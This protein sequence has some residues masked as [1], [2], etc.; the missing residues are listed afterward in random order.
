[1]H[2]SRNGAGHHDGQVR[3]ANAVFT[4]QPNFGDGSYKEGVLEETTDCV[5]FEFRSP[6]VIAATP[7]NSDAWG[8]YDQG[9]R[10]GLVLEGRGVQASVSTDGGASW[11][12]KT[13][14]AGRLDLTDI[15]KGGKQYWL[16][17]GFNSRDELATAGLRWTTVCQTNV[18]VLPRLK[19]EGSEITYQAS[20]QALVSAGPTIAQAKRHLVAGGFGQ[21]QVTLELATPRGEPVA[22]VFAATQVASSNPPDPR[23]NYQIEVA[24][25]GSGAWQPLVRDWN[26][27]RRGQEPGDFWSQSFCWGSQRLKQETGKVKVRFTNNGGKTNLRSEM[28]LAYRVGP[29]D[30]L[31]VTYAWSDSKSKEQRASNVFGPSDAAQTWRIPTAKSVVTRWVEMEP[32]QPDR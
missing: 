1:M 17:I 32:A 6:Y 11:S 25:D 4:Y 16:R 12:P 15:V 9:C 18:A 27:P 21:K 3:F 14:L 30:P 19:E 7:P 8:I 2:G 5:T 10:N 22:E 23:V 24:L 13:T 31:R 28:H 20:G 26:I 29:T